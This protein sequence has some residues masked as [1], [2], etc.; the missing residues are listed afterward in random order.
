MEK[1]AI[2]RGL[3]GEQNSLCNEKARIF[4]HRWS[5]WSR[6]LRL[7]IFYIRVLNAETWF[8]LGRDWFDERDLVLIANE[9]ALIVKLM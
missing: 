7:R 5:I 6:N 1:L 3:S 8:E 2:F 9:G 4:C